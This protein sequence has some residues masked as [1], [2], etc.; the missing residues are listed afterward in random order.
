MTK[1]QLRQVLNIIDMEGFDYTFNFYSQFKEVEDKEFH[2]LRQAYINATK[3]LQEYL[4][5]N[6]SEPEDEDDK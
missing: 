1:K 3:A 6:A 4:D 2:K 5:N